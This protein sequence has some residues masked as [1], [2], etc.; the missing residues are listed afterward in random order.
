MIVLIKP[1]DKS[2]YKNLVDI[3]DEMT[4][5]G[6]ASYAIVDITEKEVGMMKGNEIY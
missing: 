6:I 2:S 3:I 5:A 1:S 4:I